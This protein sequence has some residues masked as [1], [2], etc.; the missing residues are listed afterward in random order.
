M[1]GESEMNMMSK[2]RAIVVGFKPHDSACGK[3][4]NAK[5]LSAAVQDKQINHAR[6][7]IISTTLH[8]TLESVSL[9]H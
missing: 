7:D 9:Q 4:N 3:G 8:A 1:A 5:S 2:I 6:L